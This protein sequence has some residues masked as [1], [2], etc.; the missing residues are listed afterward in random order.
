MEW[1]QT[2]LMTGASVLVTLLVTFVFNYVVNKPKEAKK[3]REEE[4]AEMKAE[5]D[6]FKKEMKGV[7]EDLKTART[8]ERELCC[9]DHKEVLKRLDSIS[10]ENKTQS[11]G[12]QS[13]I[14]NNLKVRYLKWIKEG[15]APMDAKDDLE[16]MYQAYHKL[17]ANGVMDGLRKEFMALPEFLP[18]KRKK[19]QDDVELEL[20]EDKDDD[21]I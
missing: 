3:R 15:Y 11:A 8:H 17:G 2:L 12:L 1:W 5:M 13:V 20:H 14:K 6:N 7:V 16:R 9:E 21:E 4:K 10:A 19:S 18:R